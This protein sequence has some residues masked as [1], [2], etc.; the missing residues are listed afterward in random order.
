MKFK[1]SSTPVS[2]GMGVVAAIPPVFCPP[3]LFSAT[4]RHFFAELVFYCNTVT[5]LF[6]KE[7]KQTKSR[8]SACY[9]RSK[10]AACVT[11]L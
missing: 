5:F 4:F 9:T 8:T 10:N 11:L 2:V 6:N 3:G 1:I 7:I